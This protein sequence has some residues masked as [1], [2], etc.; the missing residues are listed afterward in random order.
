VCVFCADEETA[1]G[2]GGDATA[3][4]T[5]PSPAAAAGRALRF[6]HHV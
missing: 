5:P 4:P 1:E 6:L 3:R 2:G